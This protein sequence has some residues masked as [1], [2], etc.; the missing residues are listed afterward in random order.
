[1]PRSPC[2]AVE[3]PSAPMMKFVS[4]PPP[5]VPPELQ[6]DRVSAAAAAPALSRTVRTRER[7]RLAA[8][9]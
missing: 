3:M 4:P 1:M 6:A 8:L 7:L 2:L 5:E 9:M